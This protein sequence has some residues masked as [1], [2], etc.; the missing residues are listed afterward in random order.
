MPVF[1]VDTELLHDGASLRLE[2][3]DHA[4]QFSEAKNLPP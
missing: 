4:P 1:P 3:I 2:K